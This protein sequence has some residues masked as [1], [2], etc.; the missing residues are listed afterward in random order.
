[1]IL[2][3]NKDKD[4]WM[5]LL[6]KFPNT[7]QDI[8]YHPEYLNLNC[9]KRSRLIPFIAVLLEVKEKLAVL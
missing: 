9:L 6:N 5:E 3:S 7:L 4:Y 2:N 8:Y 1:M